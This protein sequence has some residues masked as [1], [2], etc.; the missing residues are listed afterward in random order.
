MNFRS[1]QD[2]EEESP[3]PVKCKVKDLPTWRVEVRGEEVLGEL[4]VQHGHV[5]RQVEL[6]LVGR[7]ELV[8]AGALV[9]GT[10]HHVHRE[11]L[12]L[13]HDAALE[14]SR[15]AGAHHATRRARVGQVTRG[16][17][18]GHR[19]M[20]GTARRLP[21]IARRRH[22]LRGPGWRPRLLGRRHLVLGRHLV[23]RR[24]LVVGRGR[25]AHSARFPGSHCVLA[26][27]AEQLLDPRVSGSNVV[28]VTEP[29]LSFSS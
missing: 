5:G 27:R 13:H 10:R 14:E 18:V 16:P 20:A 8:V 26:E 22:V 15:R 7:Q 3:Y 2:L 17:G 19:D 12:Q 21:G 25:G 29:Q 4:E 6:L 28:G 1:G 11:V 9:V 23:L 24:P